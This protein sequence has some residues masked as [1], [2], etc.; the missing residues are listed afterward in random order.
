MC[1]SDGYQSV[2]WYLYKTAVAA[3]WSNNW[4]TTGR[5]ILM[6]LLKLIHQIF[7]F[8]FVRAYMLKW[9]FTVLDLSGSKFR[10]KK[11]VP[12][13][14]MICGFL[15]MVSWCTLLSKQFH[16]FH[17]IVPYKPPIIWTKREKQTRQ[18]EGSSPWVVVIISV[19]KPTATLKMHLHSTKAAKEATLQTHTEKQRGRER[20]QF[21]VTAGNDRQKVQSVNSHMHRRWKHIQVEDSTHK[22][23]LTY[24]QSCIEVHTQAPNPLTTLCPTHSL[25]RNVISMLTLTVICRRELWLGKEWRMRQ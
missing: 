7:V 19:K 14:E 22:Y 24:K 23:N 12:R 25:L 15:Y 1:M 18:W 8:L 9:H 21:I 3:W 11:D 4:C 20:E 2:S 16:V 5:M 13:N 10:K 17:V 6:R